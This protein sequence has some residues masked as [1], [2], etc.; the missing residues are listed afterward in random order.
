MCIRDRNNKPQFPGGVSDQPG[1]GENQGKKRKNGQ[2]G[3]KYR[4]YEDKSTQELQ[5]RAQQAPKSY[6]S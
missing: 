6:E 1:K 3:P 5:Q 4:G 2:T